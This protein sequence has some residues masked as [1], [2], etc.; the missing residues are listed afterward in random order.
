MN[1]EDEEHKITFT[2]K[3]AEEHK[4]FVQVLKQT[5]DSICG[6]SILLC[7][8]CPLARIHTKSGSDLCDVIDKM[9]IYLSI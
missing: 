2:F 5:R 9:F 4:R 1:I 8:A 3:N 6:R 7:N